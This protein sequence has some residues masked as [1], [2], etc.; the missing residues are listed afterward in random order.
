MPSSQV[1]NQLLDYASEPS[2]KDNYQSQTQH[3]NHHLLLLLLQARCLHA[4]S[5]V[6]NRDHAFRGILAQI[7]P[8]THAMKRYGI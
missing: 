6:Q 3:L 7:L 4:V 5:L 8:I 1:V 2:L